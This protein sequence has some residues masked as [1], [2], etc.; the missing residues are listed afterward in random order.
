M[1]WSNSKEVSDYRDVDPQRRK[2]DKK[3]IKAG[4]KITL[5]RLRKTFQYESFSQAAMAFDDT[6]NEL[7]NEERL[8]EDEEK[9]FKRMH[10][11]MKNKLIAEITSLHEQTFAAAGYVPWLQRNSFKLAPD[12]EAFEGIG[13]E[14]DQLNY[15]LK[16]LVLRETIWTVAEQIRH[17][18]QRL[19]AVFYEIRN[20]SAAIHEYY[21]S[22]NAIFNFLLLNN[23]NLDVHTA[24]SKWKKET[25]LKLMIP[26]FELE[27]VRKGIEDFRKSKLNFD[28]IDDCGKWNKDPVKTFN[29]VP[30]LWEVFP[31]IKYNSNWM[32]LKLWNFA[33]VYFLY[34]FGK[35]EFLFVF[36]GLELKNP[37]VEHPQEREIRGLPASAAFVTCDFA[38][39]VLFLINEWVCRFLIAHYRKWS[40]L[41]WYM[42]IKL[43]SG[44]I[45]PILLG[46]GFAGYTFSFGEDTERMEHLHKFSYIYMIIRL[47]F[48][49]VDF[50]PFSPWIDTRNKN[51]DSEI[52]RFLRCARSW[53]GLQRRNL[54]RYAFILSVFAVASWYEYIAIAPT[55]SILLKTPFCGDKSYVDSLKFFGNVLSAQTTHVLCMVSS[56]A[57]WTSTLLAIVVDNGLCF[58]TVMAIVGWI[59]GYKT[60]GTSRSIIQIDLETLLKK[61]TQRFIQPELIAAERSPDNTALLRDMDLGAIEEN[62]KATEENDRRRKKQMETE[63]KQKAK[64]LWHWCVRYW[65]KED[66]LSTAEAKHFMHEFIDSS[67][68]TSPDAEKLISFFINSLDVEPHFNYDFDSIP[69]STV[70][71]PCFDEKLEFDW[72]IGPSSSPRDEFIHLV[73][74]FPYEWLNF[75]ERLQYDHG[76]PA[77]VANDLE[78]IVMNDPDSL[79]PELK[80]LV[81]NWLSMRDQYF[82]KTIVGACSYF[83]A[84]VAL[85]MLK[86]G[87][88]RREAEAMAATKC[89]VIIAMQRYQAR[90]KETQ[91]VLERWC[92]DFPCLQFVMNYEKRDAR[93]NLAPNHD[94]PFFRNI[95]ENNVEFATCLIDFDLHAQALVIRHILPRA[96]A[97]RLNNS[98]NRF[99]QGKSMNQLYALTFAFGRFIQVLD[100]NQGAHATEYLKFPSLLKDFKLKS[101]GKIRYRII[102]SREYI[103]T[104][105]LGTIARAHAYQEWSFGTLVLRTYSD[106]GIRLHYGHPDVF[107]APWAIAMAGLSKVNPDINTSEDVFAGFRTMLSGENTKHVEHIQF[108][109]GRETGLGTMTVFDTKI[110]AG[111]ASLLRSRDV[112]HLMERLDFVTGFLFLHG[113]SGH[114]LTIWLMMASMKIYILTLFLVSLAGNSLKSIGNTTFATEWLFHMGLTTIIPLIVEFLVEYGPIEGFLRAMFFIPV[115]TTIYLFQM[116]SKF[117]AFA[118]GVITGESAH[119]NTGRGLAIYRH[120]FVEIFR[121]YGFSHFFPI[122]NVMMLTFAYYSLSSDLG[123]GTL[124][125]IMIYVLCLSVICSPQIFNPA[126]KGN[127]MVEL[128]SDLLKFFAWVGKGDAIQF[129]DYWPDSVDQLVKQEDTFTTYCLAHDY[130][131]LPK[132]KAKVIP[133]IIYHLFFFVLYSATA[134]FIYPQIQFWFLFLFGLWLIACIFNFAIHFFFKSYEAPLRFVCIYV[135][136]L[137]TIAAIVYKYDGQK[138]FTAIY[139]AGIILVK[140]LEAFRALLLD[141]AVVVSLVKY[142]DQAK[143]QQKYLS[144]TL[145]VLNKIFFIQTCRAV[146]AFVWVLPNFVV[147]ILMRPEIS[148]WMLFGNNSGSKTF[149]YLNEMRRARATRRGFGLT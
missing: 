45:Q 9:I 21:L 116:Q 117:Y 90:I 132:T 1:G 69:P 29:E 65:Q 4:F 92:Q 98:E 113:V 82:Y 122:F 37:W 126:L 70:L 120:S 17:C 145:N 57:L 89:Q 142:A 12:L 134:V 42:R 67:F 141:A 30:G 83:H 59:R 121:T 77:D 104:K 87:R 85:A 76:V 63:S 10:D 34:E 32:Q 131:M 91:S 124:P 112:Y 31:I 96:F 47:A 148:N 71:V 99:I 61:I 129:F 147:G 81:T 144:F 24:I 123:G 7:S 25:G 56:A 125:L 139:L 26:Q 103:F 55:V 68:L 49:L 143:M 78:K 5:D 22:D 16:D 101:S 110:S 66:L 39:L 2:E 140:V 15:K 11:R 146:Y 44:I 102:G 114:F 86:P 128:S 62:R 95:Y 41:D 115:S 50:L 40:N 3:V 36:L 58:I 53:R 137:M 28:D 149:G 84:L 109:K 133:T 100:A 75:I 88:D 80:Q 51:S 118:L 93:G 35:K 108:Q 48:T 72:R 74:K 136:F 138:N 127:S 20:N 52:N 94:N 119:I 23:R 60:Q 73:S 105:N 27:N 106:L 8:N 38:M 130:R 43:A 6:S 14:D 19:N 111:N 107:H 46:G 79:D 54:A 13:P 33:L 18:P 64:E 97:L 135:A